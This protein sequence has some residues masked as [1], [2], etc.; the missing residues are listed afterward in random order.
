MNHK[1]FVVDV[2]EC[3]ATNRL[4]EAVSML[5]SF[6]R[7]RDVSLYQVALTQQTR[8]NELIEART[9]QTITP[10]ESEN[11]RARI[12]GVL[13]Y[14]VE[15]V[16]ELP[17]ADSKGQEFKDDRQ[18]RIFFIEK[19]VLHL[20]Q[21]LVKLKEQR[22]LVEENPIAEER[23]DEQIMDFERWIKDYEQELTQLN[24]Q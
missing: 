13:T 4:V 12:R 9:M 24:P 16:A 8:L 19:E 11:E 22:T 7:N 21:L 15:K 1:T 20:K 5:V 14:V 23:Y 17:P 6:L 10:E 18:K 3:I 2:E